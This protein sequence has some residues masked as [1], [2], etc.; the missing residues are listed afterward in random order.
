MLRRVTSTAEHLS[1]TVPRRARAPGAAQRRRRSKMFS[2]RFV[3]AAAHFHHPPP[4]FT[5]RRRL[6]QCRRLCPRRPGRSS[7]NLRLAYQDVVLAKRGL[8]RS[9]DRRRRAR[10]ELIERYEAGHEFDRFAANKRRRR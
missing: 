3:L 1:L 5:T 7:P 9:A 10:E 8:E 2:S 6:P 4:L